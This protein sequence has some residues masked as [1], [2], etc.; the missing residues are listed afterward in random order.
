[1]MMNGCPP[2]AAITLAVPFKR[3]GRAKRNPLDGMAA[4][5]KLA[6]LLARSPARGRPVNIR[7]PLRWRSC[8][9][10]PMF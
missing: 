6:E 7:A 8:R 3:A 9:F 4:P 5:E 1:V 10:C 2:R